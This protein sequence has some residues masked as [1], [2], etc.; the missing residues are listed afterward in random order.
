MKEYKH[1][2]LGWTAKQRTAGDYLLFKKLSPSNAIA[3]ELIE[4]SC[5]WEQISEVPKYP[6]QYLGKTFTA[7]DRN[8]DEEIY[9][10]TAVDGNEYVISWSFR[11]GGTS[12]YDIEKVN[13]YFNHGHWK[14]T[15]KK[16]KTYTILSLSGRNGLH[17]VVN[18]EVKSMSGESMLRSSWDTLVPEEL[19][20]T[21]PDVWSIHSIK[22]NSDGEVFTL[23]DTIFY[24]DEYQQ[25][26]SI[27]IEASNKVQMWFR[28]NGHTSNFGYHTFNTGKVYRVKLTTADGKL[29]VSGDEYF[30]IYNNKILRYNVSD[31]SKYAP[32]DKFYWGTREAAENH[33]LSTK[34]CL[35][36]E[37]VQKAY[38]NARPEY[39]IM[40]VKDFK[41][42]LYKIVKTK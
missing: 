35:S 37:D 40:G 1:K 7:H 13:E 10:I 23:G 9:T 4:D 15:N 18:G 8:V 36:V 25:I 32:M 27:K 16:P 14:L 19:V 3:K 33:L 2:K 31:T 39:N 38:K 30:Y 29:L 24:S 22:R 28:H 11:N 5:D 41:E 34:P 17:P 21:R 6:T 20:S 12:R 26:T 42:E